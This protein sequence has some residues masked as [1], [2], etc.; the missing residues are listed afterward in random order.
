MSEFL[1][2]CLC[3]E[4][5]DNAALEEKKKLLKQALEIAVTLQNESK[6]KG[7]DIL[8]RKL[9]PPGTHEMKIFLVKKLLIFHSCVATES[10]QCCI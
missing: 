6:S 5:D 9:V 8:A 4:N 1:V 10:T 2:A 7:P 3:V